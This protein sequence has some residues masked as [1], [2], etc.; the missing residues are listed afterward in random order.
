[1]IRN[2]YRA[3]RIEALRAPPA[4]IEPSPPP[5]GGPPRFVFLGRVESNK[6]VDWLLEAAA[7]AAS[8]P[9][10]DVVGDG[11]RLPEARER[12]ARLGIG[13]Q[14]S[15]HGWLP[16]PDALDVLRRAR[17]LVLP[18]LWHEPGAAVAVEA[19]AAGRAVI[20]SGVGGMTEIVPEGRNGILVE[21]NDV[22]GL[23]AAL[24]RLANDLDLACRM[25]AE[26]RELVEAEYALPVHMDRLSRLY[27]RAQELHSWTAPVYESIAASEE[28]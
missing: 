27:T 13:S 14:V 1:M 11:A 5:A 19:M 3:D 24:D 18:S 28:G 25:G 4:P 7:A 12:A 17:A 20:M 26:G 15:F 23:A 10:I 22:A 9:H 8:R 16:G 2:G 6:G 21:P